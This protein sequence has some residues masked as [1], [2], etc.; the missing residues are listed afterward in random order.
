MDLFFK[1]RVNRVK[2]VWKKKCTCRTLCSYKINSSASSQKCIR[3]FAVVI[4]GSCHSC[5]GKGKKGSNNPFHAKLW[6]I[7]CLGRSAVHKPKRSLLPV[8]P[9]PFMWEKKKKGMKKSAWVVA[10]YAVH[11]TK[12]QI[13]RF[14]CF[15]H[16]DFK[17]FSLLYACD[18]PESS[19]CSRTSNSVSADEVG[20]KAPPCFCISVPAFTRQISFL[21]YLNHF[22]ILILMWM[23]LDP[24]SVCLE[25]VL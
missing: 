5:L 24:A 9:Q 4:C 18:V 1:G 11:A 21:H 12:H 7:S 3:M 2:K 16:S 20:K 6:W 10:L 15:I 17:L 22:H 8:L 14:W 13:F 25:F 23:S 19:L